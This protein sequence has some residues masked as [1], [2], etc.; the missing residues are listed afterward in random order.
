MISIVVV[1][2]LAGLAL[3]TQAAVLALQRAY[4]AQGR[5]IEV[6]GAALHV[7]E[8]GPRDATGPPVVMIDGA[9]SNLEAMRHPLGAMLARNHRVILIDR[10]GH[11]WSTRADLADSTPA[12]QGRMI[13]EALQKLG[14]GAC[15]N[16]H[17]SILSESDSSLGYEQV[18]SS[19]EYRSDAA[20][21]AECA[22]LCAERPCLAVYR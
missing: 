7:L 9:S 17:C 4:P 11:G 14:L 15:P 2:V 12:I 18:F 10:P 20:S 13:D 19:L 22:G 16:S 6:A 8:L 5:M 1:A 21:A 3:M